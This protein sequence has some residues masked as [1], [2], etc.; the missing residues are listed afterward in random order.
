MARYDFTAEA[1]EDLREIGRYTKKT[2]GIAQARHYREEIKLALEML[3]LNPKAGRERD[4]VAPKLR[5]FPVAKH[6]A[7][8]VIR[9]GGITIVRL[10]HPGMDVETAFDPENEKP[11]KTK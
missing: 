10:L 6:I 7:F 5:S 1:A 9:R 3:G 11:D 4:E 8:Y 2:W